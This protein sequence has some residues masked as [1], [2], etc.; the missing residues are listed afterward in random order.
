[1][2]VCPGSCVIEIC[3]VA[4]C[5]HFMEQDTVVNIELFKMTILLKPTQSHRLEEN[6]L[7]FTCF[8]FY[9]TTSATM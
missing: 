2:S 5:L 6:V 1:M 4:L 9:N 3:I 7:K 8:L